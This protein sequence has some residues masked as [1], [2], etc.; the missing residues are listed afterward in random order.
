MYLDLLHLMPDTWLICVLHKLADVNDELEI[1]YTMTILLMQNKITS[2]NLVPKIVLSRFLRMLS[3]NEKP[4]KGNG[5]RKK[6]KSR[7][8]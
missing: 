5:K 7:E 4:R 8:N 2:V 6:E 1:L 3:K